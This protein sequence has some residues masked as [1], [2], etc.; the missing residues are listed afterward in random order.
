MKELAQ[1]FNVLQIFVIERLDRNDGMTP[2]EVR[3]LATLCIAVA[4]AL[5]ALDWDAKEKGK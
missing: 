1:M 3:T 2:D 4:A 5:L